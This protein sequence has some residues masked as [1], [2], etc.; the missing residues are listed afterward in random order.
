MRS[1]KMP[2]HRLPERVLGV[3]PAAKR[4]GTDH[5]T[6][7][8]LALMGLLDAEIV[9]GLPKIS[10]ASLERYERERAAQEVA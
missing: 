10:I 7:L 5:Y 4:L 3:S 8:K 2:S 6:V 9:D 1:T